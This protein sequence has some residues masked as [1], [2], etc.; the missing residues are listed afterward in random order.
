MYM[1]D[2]FSFLECGRHYPSRAVLQRHLKIHLSAFYCKSCSMAFNSAEDKDRHYTEKHTHQFSCSICDKTFKRK[3]SL[4]TH[5]ESVHMDIQR[6]PCTWV[7]CGKSFNRRDYLDNHMNTH[8]GQR[9]HTCQ[10]CQKSY[11]S[12]ISLSQ[13]WKACKTNGLACRVCGQVLSSRS[14]LND[15]I[16]GMHD[17]KPLPCVCGQVFTWRNNLLKHKKNCSVFYDSQN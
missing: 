6:F 10:K 1:N 15:H 3:N 2:S 5:V 17:K 14:G 7:D 4:N 11:A 13:H 8:T 16:Q 12:K 9:P